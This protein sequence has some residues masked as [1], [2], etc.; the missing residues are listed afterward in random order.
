MWI[1]V[2]RIVSNL[3]C[4]TCAQCTSTD[5]PCDLAAWMNFELSTRS[6]SGMRKLTAS[7]QLSSR[8]VT[9]R[10][11]LA[12]LT[13]SWGRQRDQHE[14]TTHPALKVTILLSDSHATIL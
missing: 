14:L 2:Y 5:P 3:P 8:N 9:P 6:G 4:F 11:V 1:A 12:W 13:A 7:S 10:S